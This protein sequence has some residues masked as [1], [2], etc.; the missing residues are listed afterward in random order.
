MLI[1]FTA[2]WN[3]LQPF[4]IFYS[5][6]EYFTAIWNILQLFGIFYSHLVYIVAITYILWSFGNIFPVLGI[7]YQE[8][9]GNPGLVYGWL[10]L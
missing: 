7:L 4:G 8:Q 6:L 3:I 9:S 10:L 2:I 1:Y 5:H